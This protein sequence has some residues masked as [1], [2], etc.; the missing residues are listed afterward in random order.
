M[1]IELFIEWLWIRCLVVRA[2]TW[3][4]QASLCIPAS[5]C[6]CSASFLKK[7]RRG[8]A[9]GLTYLCD[10]SKLRIMTLLIQRGKYS[11]H[12]LF[13]HYMWSYSIQKK[14]P[15]LS[16]V[17]IFNFNALPAFKA[18][19]GRLPLVWQIIYEK[20]K[21][22][23]SYLKSTCMTVSLHEPLLWWLFLQHSIRTT[24]SVL[25]PMG[26]LLPSCLS[27]KFTAFI[28]ATRNLLCKYSWLISY[29]WRVGCVFLRVE[30]LSELIFQ[31]ERK[32]VPLQILLRQACSC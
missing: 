13:I 11:E 31:E 15:T 18:I 30:K 16:F 6:S 2:V 25:C 14:T 23:Q 22:V 24:Y 32:G 27:C 8:R 21:I 17:L 1:N 4:M 19:F 5:V 9:V 28:A 29:L 3:E 7:W 20:K 10:H 26:I 12:T